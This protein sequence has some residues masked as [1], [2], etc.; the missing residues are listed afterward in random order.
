[1]RLLGRKA[2]GA[3]SIYLVGGATAVLI[4]WRDT[5]ADVD[6]KLA[7]EPAG[8]FEAI[9]EAKTALNMN[10]ELAAPDDFIPAL[11]EWRERSTFIERHGLIDFFHYD[12][13]AQAL[14]KIERAHA[15]DL[16]DVDAMLRRKLIQPS[17]L[18]GFFSVME[19]SLTRYPAVDPASFRNQLKRA[20]QNTQGV[21]S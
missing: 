17:R 21:N 9:A 16:Q 7:P 10:I 5:T 18:E 1:M 20:M 8:V 2:T 12:F 14:A 15:Q 3:G 11:P 6:I 4:G 19:A 13:Y